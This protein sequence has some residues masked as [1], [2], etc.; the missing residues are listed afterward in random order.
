MTFYI[1][2]IYVYIC[3][4]AWKNRSYLHKIHLFIY[5]DAY[6]L[7]CMCYPKSVNFIDFLIAFYIYDV[8]LDMIQITDKSYNLL[9]FKLSKSGQILR[10]DK[11][12]FLRPGYIYVNLIIKHNKIVYEL[13]HNCSSHGHNIEHN[14]QLF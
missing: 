14:R 9:H 7:F 13:W 2:Y 3:D 1:I 10:I 8:V 11:T 6:L 4:G 5:Y 12:C